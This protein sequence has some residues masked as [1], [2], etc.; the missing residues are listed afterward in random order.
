[1]KFIYQLFLIITIIIMGSCSEDAL[2]V[3]KEPDNPP[4]IEEEEENNN[5]GDPK[6]LY[7]GIR[8]PGRW[9]PI[10]SYTS[11]LENGMN[12]FY[13]TDKPETINIEI[14]RQL[15][16]DNFLIE[17]TDLERKFHYPEY[18]YGNPVLS[19][20]KEWEKIGTG[21]ASFAAP[22]SDGVW[23]DEEENK[24]KMWYMAGGGEYS[25]NGAGITCYAESDDGIVWTKPS[26]SVVSGTNIVD[27]NSDRDAS[28]IWID[29]Q[30]SNSSKRY[31]MFQ[32]ARNDGKWLYHYKTSADGKLWRQNSLSKPLA[33]RSTVY[34]NPFR[35]NWVFSM[36]HNI[37]VNA[38]KLVR[39]RDYNEH[40]DPDLGTKTS[41]ALLSSFWFGPWPNEIRHPRFPDVSPA[42]YN[43]DATAYESIM[44]GFFNVW[45]GPENDVSAATGEIKRNQIMVGYSRDGYSWFR[46]DMTP[47]LPVDE[48]E[49]AWN[50]GNLQSTAGNPLIVED[51]LYFYISGR[52]NNT[53]G[54]QIT[55]TGLA[56]LRRDGFTSM[57]TETSGTLTTPILDFKGEYFFV[58][59]NVNGDLKVEVLDEKGEIINGFSKDDCLGFNGN[60]TKQIIQ[61]KE[62]ATLKSL[63]GQ[64]IKLKF[65]LEKGEIYSFWISPTADGKSGGYTG[66]G[67]PGYH[68]SGIDV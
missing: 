57:H 53:S 37:R 64:K 36:R 59:A 24:F 63:K 1:M 38:N 9:P 12:P 44:L 18:H 66:G 16:V 14:G 35:D 34:K 30:E 52:R 8:L 48:T 61:W 3:E 50:Y 2:P 40:T 46:E 20:D 17:N 5:E 65:Y 62:N 29:K 49:G 13:L 25:V 47:F 32:V 23:Y 67:G 22:F 54:N 28:V 51:K 60:E 21:G 68:I 6:L 19:A 41:E 39:A 56:T 27:Y 42:I 15:F 4:V 26:L 45:Q 43:H 58:N 11:D 31:K 55:T 10:R 7:N 33:D